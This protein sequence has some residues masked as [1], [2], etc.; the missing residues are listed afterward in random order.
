[1]LKTGGL[2]AARASGAL[3]IMTA[4]ART[5]GGRGATLGSRLQEGPPGLASEG[6]GLP[7]EGKGRPG[8]KNI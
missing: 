5:S 2:I 7:I 3:D 4:G 1:M 6:L 8:G